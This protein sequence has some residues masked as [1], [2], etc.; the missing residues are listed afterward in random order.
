[1]TLRVLLADDQPLVRQGLR[2]ILEAEADIEVVGEAGDGMEAVALGRRLR[3]DVTAMDIRMPRMNGIEATRI[4]A[5]PGTRDPLAIL[6]L[7]TFDTDEEVEGALEAGA[8]GYLLKDASASEV[9]RAVRVCARGEALLAPSVTRWVLDRY[10]R[11]DPP[12]GAGR[13]GR[14]VAAGPARGPSSRLADLTE[15]EREVLLL[16]AQ[17]LSNAEIGRHLFVSETTV[18]S[19]V[20]SILGKL[21]LRDRVQATV[22]AY[23]EGLASPREDRERL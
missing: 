14:D 7:T 4:L 12:A 10:V 19:H 6:I 22:L 21:D 13:P 5:G 11:S 18:K 2:L 3:P 17:G 15:R 23:E 20:R 16:V 8:R 9:V 1:M